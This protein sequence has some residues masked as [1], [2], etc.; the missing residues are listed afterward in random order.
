MIYCLRIDRQVA[1]RKFAMAKFDESPKIEKNY[2][3]TLRTCEN[4][5][6]LMIFQYLPATSNN[7]EIIERCWAQRR[8]FSVVVQ[9]M[10]KEVASVMLS[11]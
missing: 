9:G 4:N 3:V 1:I 2:K 6:N 5:E 10:K 7:F 11:P 8:K